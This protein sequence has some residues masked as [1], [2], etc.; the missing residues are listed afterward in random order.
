MSNYL[1]KY[2][3]IKN[4]FSPSTLHPSP[5][6]LDMTVTTCAHQGC[7]SSGSLVKGCS[8]N[9]VFF[10]KRQQNIS[11]SGLSVYFLGVRVCTHI[12]Q[13]EHQRCSRTG[14]FQKI[15]K[16]LSKNVTIFNEH[17]AF[18]GAGHVVELLLSLPVWIKNWNN[19]EIKRL[20]EIAIF[21]P[22]NQTEREIQ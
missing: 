22:Q 11:N 1:S 2:L 3:Q 14:R 16:I 10:F 5:T 12:R 17:P 18:K 15:H 20:E 4:Q 21:L 6:F 8:L 9:I 19:V 7:P 13:V